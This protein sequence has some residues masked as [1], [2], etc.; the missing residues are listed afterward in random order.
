MKTM[1]IDTTKT[2][3]VT[4]YGKTTTDLGTLPGADVKALLKGY[5]FD[6]TFDLWFS[7]KANIGYDVKEA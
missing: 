6:E 7:P 3:K 5:A 1:T 4:K 2:Y